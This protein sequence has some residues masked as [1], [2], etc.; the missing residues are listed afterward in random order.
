MQNCMCRMSSPILWHTHGKQNPVKEEETRASPPLCSWPSPVVAQYVTFFYCSQCCT[1]WPFYTIGEKLLIFKSYLLT[2]S[3]TRV[4]EPHKAHFSEGYTQVCAGLSTPR[5]WQVTTCGK[6][7]ERSHRTTLA[8]RTAAGPEDW[9]HVQ[10]AATPQ[11]KLTFCPHT[12]HP[13]HSSSLLPKIWL[14]T[15]TMG[16][17]EIL[18]DRGKGR[19][20]K[21]Y[22]L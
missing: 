11:E 16:E 19:G 4:S 3:Q 1:S 7:A 10:L 8:P 21:R 15:T 2:S 13:H 17:W 14:P 6:R 5:S 20:Q 18:W 22:A 12:C 9:G